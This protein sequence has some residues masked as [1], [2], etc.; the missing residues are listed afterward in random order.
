MADDDLHDFERTTFTHDGKTRDVFRKGSGPAVIVIA[1]MPGIT[2]GVLT[3]ARRI[4]A[5]GCT[6]VV[7]HLFGRPGYDPLGHGTASG[8][9]YMAS[10]IVPAC[11]SRE[12][13]VFATG[14]T[15]PVT[16]W[17][18][19]LAADEHE[20]AVAPVWAPSA[21]AS[22]VASRWRWRSTIACSRRC[23]RNR[24]CRSASPRSTRV[25]RHL[26]E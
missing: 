18:R 6:A 25:D 12:F 22:P 24:R 3:F 11:I 14:K 23:C 5:I 17:L 1:E 4:P 20:S 19:A 26:A 15:S 2:P 10:S 7:P 9:A 16:S 13:T 21:C 8:L